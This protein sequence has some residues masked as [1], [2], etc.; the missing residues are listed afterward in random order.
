MESDD[1]KIL[2]RPYTSLKYFLTHDY[3]YLDVL[4]ISVQILSFISCKESGLFTYTL[5]LVSVTNKQPY[6][7]RT[8]DLGCYVPKHINCSASSFHV[9]SSYK[10]LVTCQPFSMLEY[11]LLF[12]LFT[13]SNCLFSI[14]AASHFIPCYSLVCCVW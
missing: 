9:P 3:S 10:L 14:F 13:M 1:L 12:L 8:G 4:A 11:H 6:E 5:I 2:N 7:F